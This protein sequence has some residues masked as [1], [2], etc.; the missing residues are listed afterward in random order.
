M[1]RTDSAA[2]FQ[3]SGVVTANFGILSIEA[4]GTSSQGTT[5]DREADGGK[6]NR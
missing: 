4:I 2:S 6:C 1:T 5:G 3:P